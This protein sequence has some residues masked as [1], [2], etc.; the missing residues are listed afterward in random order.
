M[1]KIPVVFAFDDNYALPASIAIKSLLD[2]KK[3]STHYDIFVLY[4][5]LKAET[6]EKIESITKINWVKVDRNLLKNAPRT[7]H[8]PLSVY[9]RLFIADLIPQYDKIIWSDVDV[10]FTGDLS[11]VYNMNIDDVD[12]AGIAA[13]KRSETNGV[14]Q[15]FPENK[16]P[17]VIMSGFL[18]INAKQWREKNM[19]SRFF[20]TIGKYNTKLKMF[21]LEVLNLAV[22]K[23][24]PIPFNYCVLENLY[25]A[26]DFHTAPEYPWLSHVYSDKKLQNAID[27][28]VIIHYAGP[29]VKIWNRSFNEIPGYYWKYLE[30]SPFYNHDYYFP[31]I[32]TRIK[33]SILWL[34]IKITPIKKWRKR[35]RNTRRKLS[36][37]AG[38]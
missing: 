10:L 13:E 25:V 31:G 23:I 3:K 27:H 26:E 8:W 15:H 21:D 7:D 4:D 29:A 24:A 16:K 30:K 6:I 22:D 38:K 33:M 37:V 28:P 35:M 1:K 20:D 14:H 18:L 9:Y 5:D 17:F 2:S 34:L 12:W 32:N 11:D 36:S 19:L